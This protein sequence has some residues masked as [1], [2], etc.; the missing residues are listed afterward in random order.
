MM[1]SQSCPGGISNALLNYPGFSWRNVL[2]LYTDD[3]FSQLEICNS[4]QF[5]RNLPIIL[6]W[7]AIEYKSR[8]GDSQ[9]F[10]RKNTKYY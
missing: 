8:E 3:L 9:I 7:T 5:Y 2:L 4:E 10:K 6:H 1:V